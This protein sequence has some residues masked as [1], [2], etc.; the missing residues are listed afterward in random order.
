MAIVIS[1]YPKV[2][3]EVAGVAIP[4]ELSFRFINRGSDDELIA[5]CKGASCLLAGSISG[6]IESRILENLSDIKLIHC[7]GAGYDHIDIAAATRLGI[8]IAN[9]PGQNT[10]AVAELAVSFM[11][12]LLRQ[13]V[14]SD[15]E[16]KAGNYASC[17]AKLVRAGI[18]QLSDSRV[19]LMGLGAI[20]R[21]VARLAGIMEAS[22]SYFDPFRQPPKVEADL[23]ITY[24]AFD[25][26]LANSDIV[27]IHI[28]LT[29][30]TRD[31]IERRE[32]SLMPA[33]GMLIN[34]AR[35]EV[36]NQSDLAEALEIGHIAGAAI[37]TLHPEPPGS[38]HPLLNLSP[39]ASNR[40]LMTPHIAGSTIAATKGMLTVALKNMLL[41]ARGESVPT[42]VNEITRRVD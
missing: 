21:E 24:R 7:I 32:L 29:P 9:A 31:L 36:V 11:I 27:S 10:L 14:T 2:G 37:D 23:K 28:P 26:L 15:H 20:G 5:A 3:F 34:T 18:R 40:L 42:T 19:G 39:T 25:D 12:A 33:G 22:L 38:D 8:P 4:E 35:G 17:R 41:A 16:I 13:F 1:L 30:E 6:K